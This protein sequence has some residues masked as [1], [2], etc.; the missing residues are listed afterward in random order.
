M[1]KDFPMVID[2]FGVDGYNDALTTENLRCLSD[3]LRTIDCR[4]VDRDFI[5]SR[6]EKIPNIFDA[7]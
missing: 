5:R 7:C 2:P 6:P 4:G 3:K 1:G